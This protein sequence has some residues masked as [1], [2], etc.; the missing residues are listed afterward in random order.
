MEFIF[1]EQEDQADDKRWEAINELSEGN[2][3]EAI[4]LLNEAIKLKSASMYAKRWV[5][6]YCLIYWGNCSLFIHPSIQ[7]SIH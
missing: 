6:I 7:P 2:F 4:K 3:N 5:V 1:E